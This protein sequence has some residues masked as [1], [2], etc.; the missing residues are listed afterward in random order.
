M[1]KSRTSRNDH[2]RTASAVDPDMH[3]Q[4]TRAARK[5][6]ISEE[7][8]TLLMLVSDY[9][10]LIKTGDLIRTLG[11]GLELVD[12]GLKIAAMPSATDM[13]RAYKV[14]LFEKHFC[15]MM[16]AFDHA[17]VATIADAAMAAERAFFADPG[18]SHH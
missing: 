10:T 13:E 9:Q 16:Q 7:N 12:L 14:G 8:R 2:R 15:M 18:R 5:C 1:S 6:S 11:A 4:Y 3:A 17:H